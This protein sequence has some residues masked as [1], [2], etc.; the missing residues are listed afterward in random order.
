METEVT[1]I[2][3]HGLWILSNKQEYFLSYEQFPWFKDKTVNEIT[4][5]ES[6]SH[7][8]LYWESL[9]IDLSLEMIEHPERF[10]LQAH[11]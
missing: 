8:H 11:I 1:N 3:S 6:F 10:P 7:G 4:S 5:V 2:S 9:D